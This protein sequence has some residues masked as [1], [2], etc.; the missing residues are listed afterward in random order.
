VHRTDE[1]GDAGRGPPRRADAGA[2]IRNDAE[3]A[4]RGDAVKRRETVVYYRLEYY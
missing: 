1:P 3:V 2:H 4:E